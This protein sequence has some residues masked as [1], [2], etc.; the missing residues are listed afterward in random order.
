[1]SP[2]SLTDG[3]LSSKHEKPVMG[4]QGNSWIRDLTNLL[5]DPELEEP[6]GMGWSR[7]GRNLRSS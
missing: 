2:Q 1:M 7:G 4:L 5:M 6:V 3:M